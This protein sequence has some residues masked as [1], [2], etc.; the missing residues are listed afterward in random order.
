MLSRNLSHNYILHNLWCTYWTCLHASPS[1]PFQ[2]FKLKK[3]KF[4]WSTNSGSSNPSWNV[5]YFVRS[6]FCF[7]IPLSFPPMKWWVPCHSLTPFIFQEKFTIK[8]FQEVKPPPKLILSSEMHDLTLENRLK[9]LK[10]NYCFQMIQQKWIC[11]KWKAQ[12]RYGLW[13]GYQICSA[14]LYKSNIET[15]TCPN[16]SS[17]VWIWIWTNLES[18]SDGKSAT[19]FHL[20]SFQLD[21]SGGP[22]YPA[23]F[24]TLWESARMAIN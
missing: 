11:S 23:L 15:S 5:H 8:I 21:A 14:Q 16:H 10:V 13:N 9:K 7:F 1:I 3:N 24:F 20:I 12:Y 22:F 2:F 6:T 4:F 18:K 19:C 17:L